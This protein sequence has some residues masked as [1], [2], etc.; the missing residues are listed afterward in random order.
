V[1]SK[2][3]SELLELAGGF[4]AT[5]TR[6]LPIQLVRRNGKDH[7]TVTELGFSGSVAP[8]APLLDDD[9]VYVRDV[10]ELQRSV[11]LIGAVVG[12]DPLDAATASKRLPFVEGDTVLSLIERAG[13]IKAPG[14]LRR[15]YISRPREG[16]RPEL[17]PIDLEA[18]L[19]RRELKADRKV[20]LADTIVVPPMR[21]S[22]LVEGAVTRAGLYNYNPAFGI[23]E[24]IAQAGGRTRV[25]R[26]IDEVKLIDQNGITHGFRANMKPSPGD[27]ILVPER[28][29]SRAEV[30]QLVLAGASVLIS[31][32]AI[33]L[34]ATR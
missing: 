5:L 30:A 7:E 10:A 28:N 14:D 34:A 16:S 21:Y 9:K 1:K 26:D 24:Y 12:A 2:D 13:G 33:T 25:A 27:S 23:S 32:I 22:V 31:G 8:N 17:I 20:E 15:S 3:L 19:V 29:F 18:L 4:T 6:S 11:L